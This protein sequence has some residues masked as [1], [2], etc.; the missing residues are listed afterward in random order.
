MTIMDFPLTPTRSNTLLPGSPALAA[1]VKELLEKAGFNTKG[2]DQRGFDHH[3]D[4]LLSLMVAAGAAQEDQGRQV[5][6]DELLGMTV[7]AYRF[8]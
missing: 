5:F 3:E 7:S 6:H 1:R 4:H 8:G 2:D